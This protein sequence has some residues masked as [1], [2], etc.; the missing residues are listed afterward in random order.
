MKTHTVQPGDTLGKIAIK[1][2]HQS[3]KYQNIA[4]A[5]NLDD[6]DLI[7]VGQELV[8]PGHEEE[9]MSGEGLQLIKGQLKAIMSK[10]TDANLDKYLGPLN[11]QMPKYGINTPLRVAHFIAQLAHESGSFKYDMENLNY[12]AK[13][14]R[15]IFGKYFKTEESAEEYARKPEDIANIVYANRMGNGDT[16][17]GDGWKFRGRGLI[18]LTGHDNY[19]SCGKGINLDLLNN[20]DL[21]SGDPLA[22]V[23]AAGWYWNSRGLNQ[24]ADQDDVKKITRLINGGYNGLADREKYLE[25]AK[26]VLID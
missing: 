12:S 2:Y 22:A 14:L 11:E 6:P 13:A 16:E 20:P 15:S 26:C 4:K 19:K 25:K 3:S 21:L 8:L 10:A 23:A 9:E 5:N 7:S 18:Q 24:Y 17:S 1:Y